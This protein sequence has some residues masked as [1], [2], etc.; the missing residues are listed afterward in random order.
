MKRTD[1]LAIEVL[2]VGAINRSSGESVEVF[3]ESDSPMPRT[4]YK[5]IIHQSALSD[6]NLLYSRVDELVTDLKQR[7]PD[8]SEDTWERL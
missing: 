7:R 8:L 3:R 6:I 1:A 2:V 5:L 4:R